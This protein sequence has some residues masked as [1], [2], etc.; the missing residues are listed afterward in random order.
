M[1]NPGY[2]YWAT[3]L[4]WSKL[5]HV[6]VVPHQQITVA[7]RSLWCWW[8]CV[9]PP[10]FPAWLIQYSVSDV[11][12]QMGAAQGVS[13]VSSSGRVSPELFLPFFFKRQREATQTC[14]CGFWILSIEWVLWLSE[15]WCR[16]TNSFQVC[17]WWRLNIFHPFFL[18]SVCNYIP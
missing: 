2:I 8:F 12:L 17:P 4:S 15:N 9:A 11:P 1:T 14:S 13:V 10:S 7:T 6:L 5:H 18:H 3:C 16:K